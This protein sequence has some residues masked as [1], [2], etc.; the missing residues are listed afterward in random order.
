MLRSLKLIPRSAYEGLQ[1]RRPRL[2]DDGEDLDDSL[3][4]TNIP[5][6]YNWWQKTILL[7]LNNLPSASVISHVPFPN[8][9]FRHFRLFD[10]AI[11]GGEIVVGDVLGWFFVNTMFRTMTVL[12]GINI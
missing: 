3:N 8:H 9:F 6:F 11:F 2:L 7:H 5:T 10:V 12:F 1:Q 4:T